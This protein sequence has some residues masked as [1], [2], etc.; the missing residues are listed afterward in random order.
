MGW[1]A[2][3]GRQVSVVRNRAPIQIMSRGGGPGHG[4]A[5]SAVDGAGPVVVAGQAAG[6][7]STESIR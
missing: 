2:C 6:G 1:R 4:P 5:P 3:K 7:M